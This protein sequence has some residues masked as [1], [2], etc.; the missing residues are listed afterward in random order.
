MIIC[1]G[2]FRIANPMNAGAQ[3]Q[4]RQRIDQE[5][6]KFALRSSSPQLPIQTR[7]ASDFCGRHR[8]EHR[9]VGGFMPGECAASPSPSPEIDSRSTLAEGEHC[10]DAVESKAG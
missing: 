6:V 1:A 10:V 7:S 2:S 8:P 4:S 3:P 5:F 9:G